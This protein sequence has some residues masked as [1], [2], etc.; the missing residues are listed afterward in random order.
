MQRRHLNH[1]AMWRA[2]GLL[3]GGM[4]QVDVARQLGVTQSVI[5]RL[6]S[7]YREHG[8]VSERHRGRERATTRRQ[9]RF[10]Q[11]NARR[12]RNITAPELQIMLQE[13]HHV[14]VSSE[15][16]RRRLRE[17]NLNS[18]RPLRVPVINRANRRARRLWAQEHV[19]WMVNDWRNVLFTDESRYGM[20]PDSRRSRVWREPGNVQRLRFAQETHRYRGG[21]IMVWG[22]I[23]LGGRTDLVLLEGSMTGVMYRDRI[24]QPIVLS[25]AESFGPAFT[26]MHDNARPHTSRVAMQFLEENNIHVL[27]WP[28]QSPDLNPIEHMWDMV[29]RRLF[30][31]GIPRES[32]SILFSALREAWHAVPQDDVDRLILSMQRRCQA[33]LNNS[34][35][36]THY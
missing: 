26:L 21:T 7:R 15:T 30:R 18:R 19:R 4:R 8:D 31:M 9:D 33:V 32:P 29:Q 25:H 23:R 16:V 36:Q 13:T 20:Y 22:G 35:G 6:Y 17:V 24:L 34:G 28:A 11:L 27:P 14:Q 1:E 3:E 5:S 2:V 10:L 12:R